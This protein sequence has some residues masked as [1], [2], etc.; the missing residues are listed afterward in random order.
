MYISRQH[1]GLHVSFS[2]DMHNCHECSSSNKNAVRLLVKKYM[3]KRDRKGRR[4][5]EVELRE[6]EVGREGEGEGRREREGRGRREGGREGER[7][8]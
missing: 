3:H 7:E 8:S 5:R 2:L 4:E 1:E 6:G